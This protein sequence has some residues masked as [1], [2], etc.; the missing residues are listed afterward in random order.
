MLDLTKVILV[1]EEKN[2]AV[3]SVEPLE[4]GYGHTLGN[5]LRRVM[6]TSLVGAAVTR[7]RIKGAPHQF[8]TLDGMA[9]DVVELLLNIKKIRIKSFSDQEVV[10]KLS[11]KGPATVTAGDI[12]KSAEVE[13]VN[14][15]LVLASLADSKSVLDVELVVEKGVGYITAD[16]RVAN[17]PA[18]AQKL[19][20][21]LLDSH[22]AP[23]TRVNYTI[24]TTRIG[25]HANYDRLSM[26]IHTDGSI[27]PMDSLHQSAKILEG[28]F[29]FL[30]GAQANVASDVVE[31]KPKVL[32]HNTEKITVD[33]LD[34]PPK[35]ANRLKENGFETVD[36]V[37]NAGRDSLLKMSNFGE[38][39]LKE[40]E[41]KL[42]EK[43]YAALK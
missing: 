41:A 25:R 13:I 26:E 23:V 30:T 31:E 4:R 7:V 15:E 42:K 2:S 17:D 38:K 27:S 39:S 9:E 20:E 3:I 18:A 12:A 37:I 14:P 11:V 24:E 34:L 33:E 8:M 36:D 1:S 22:Y 10:I 21:I 19:G 40:V 29:S 32:A 16:E 28:Y 5:G 43:G 6:L 35:I